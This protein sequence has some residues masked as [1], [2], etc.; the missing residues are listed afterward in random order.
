MLISNEDQYLCSSGI[1]DIQRKPRLSYRTLQALFN[2]EKEPLLDAGKYSE[3]TPLS[4]I[5]VGIILALIL[6][7]LINR[8]RRFREYLTR[9][10]LRPYNFYADIRDQRIM[11]TPQ[12]IFLGAGI[13][14]TLGIFLA[15]L[16]FAYRTSE[17][18][19]FLIMLFLPS[20]SMKEL[21]F[22]LIWTPQL[23]IFTFSL[24]IF[25]SIFIVA[26]IIKLF[27]FFVRARIFYT[28]SITIAIW[29]GVPALGLLPFAIILTRLLLL[30]PFFVYLM[31]L[32][33]FGVLIWIFFRILRSVAVVFDIPSMW[34]LII[35]FIFTGIIAAIFFTIYNHDY[36]FF[37]YFQYLW[38]VM[39]N[40]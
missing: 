28:D 31:M 27:S 29:S 17:F 40:V 3:G 10:V 2:E 15:S 11:S 22:S 34:S 18:T 14:I 1:V 6:V 30:T 35:G 20:S 4:F 9:A 24:L 23:S 16:L 37:A 32:L 38:E 33:F 21:L 19:Q 26:G 25:G 36:S 39:I 5:I 12:T 13:S 7:F 8:Y